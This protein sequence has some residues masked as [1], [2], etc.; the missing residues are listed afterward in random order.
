TDSVKTETSETKVNKK[1]DSEKA[2]KVEQPQKNANQQVTEK[3]KSE[4]KK[5]EIATSKNSKTS[6]ELDK[7][8]VTTTEDKKNAKSKLET[9]LATAKD[10]KATVKS[11]LSSQ[12]STIEAKTI[13]DNADINY[14]TA[15]DEE[16]NIEILKASL[17]ELVNDQES[18]TTLATPTRTMFRAMATPTALAAAV[19]QSEEVEKSLGYLDNYTF[20]SLI[21]DPGSL[22]NPTTLN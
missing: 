3:Q 22:D 16:I 7:S 17:I 11:F 20:A 15:T 12:V 18:A 19:D 13:M 6:S 2:T 14:E 8:K 5:D 4:M 1:S 21:F 10:K 9:K